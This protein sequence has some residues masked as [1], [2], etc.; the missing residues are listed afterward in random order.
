MDFITD[1]Y[2]RA[3]DS[4]YDFTN[5]VKNCWVFRKELKEHRTYDY[6][7]SLIMFKKS[8]ETLRDGLNKSQM[9]ENTILRVTE[10]DKMIE[11]L[12]R[13]I[14]DSYIEIAEK[15]LNMVMVLNTETHN[16][17]NKYTYSII[18]NTEA[19][20]ENNRLIDE[21]AKYK[22]DEDIRYIQGCFEER[23]FCWWN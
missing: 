15:S 17:D 23:L 2:Y 12:Q 22:R 20:N 16:I 13:L 10:I 19:D 8:L 21:C 11:C 5:Y 1:M 3:I 18:T 7:Y 6:N 9:H 14:E 4:V